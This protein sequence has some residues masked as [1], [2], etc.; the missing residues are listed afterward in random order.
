M[1]AVTI[2]EQQNLCCVPLKWDVITHGQPLYARNTTPFLC[3]RT[4]RERQR[5]EQKESERQPDTH[6][7]ITPSLCLPAVQLW[8]VTIYTLW[9]SQVKN[10]LGHTPAD[11]AAQARL[12]LHDIFFLSHS[13][14]LPITCTCCYEEIN[15]TQDQDLFSCSFS[16]SLS[17]HEDLN[18]YS[19]AIR[20]FSL[21]SGCLCLTDFSSVY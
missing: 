12:I 7:D 15:G 18:I 1:L 14:T 2:R 21:C 20:C 16:D 8:S 9:L 17:I 13:H 4:E 10:S 11:T 6:V 3:I 5:E 19:K